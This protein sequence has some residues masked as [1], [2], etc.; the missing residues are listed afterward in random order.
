MA[1]GV[2]NQPITEEEVFEV[3]KLVRERFSTLIRRTLEEMAKE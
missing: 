1:A 3:A 2:L